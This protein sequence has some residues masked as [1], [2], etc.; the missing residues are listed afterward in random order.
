MFLEKCRSDD[1][2][3][4]EIWIEIGKVLSPIATVGLAAFLAARYYEK[5]KRVD[6][7]LKLSEKVLEEVYTPILVMLIEKPTVF[8]GGVYNGLMYNEAEEIDKLF[9]SNYH[10]INPEI[11][12]IFGRI[13]EELDLYNEMSRVYHEERRIFVDQDRE[14]LDALIQ[15][16][17]Y[18]LKR[19][20]F[21]SKNR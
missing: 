18:H 2:T 11:R 3:T 15:E 13:K 20:G 5:N 4:S 21:Y 14:F 1:M 17:E 6:F 7:S 9:K 12:N 8:Y 10:L 19:I 16:N